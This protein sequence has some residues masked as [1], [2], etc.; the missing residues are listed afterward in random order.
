MAGGKPRVT[1][2]EPV[3]LDQ[4][5]AGDFRFGIVRGQQRHDVHAI[6]AALDFLLEHINAGVIAHRQF[7]PRT[8]HEHLDEFGPHR[9][10]AHLAVEFIRQ[11]IA[12]QRL[13]GVRRIQ[14]PIGV[15]GKSE[16]RDTPVIARFA[17]GL[18]RVGVFGETERTGT[19]QGNTGPSVV[20]G[21]ARQRGAAAERVNEPR[22]GGDLEAVGHRS[23]ERIDDDERQVGIEIDHVAA[24]QRV[25]LRHGGAGLQA[26]IKHL[27]PDHH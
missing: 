21:R 2:I 26:G 19:A 27:R 11:K 7:A 4:V 14:N 9:V 8:V 25:V 15:S 1:R 5:T 20:I 16:H 13:V 24:Q 10:V 6:F 22:V 3:L 23:A 17:L 12:H 18:E